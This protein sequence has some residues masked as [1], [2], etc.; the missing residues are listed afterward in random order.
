ML[1]IRSSFAFRYVTTVFE[2]NSFGR[3]IRGDRS[4][5]QGTLRATYMLDHIYPKSYD[6]FTRKASFSSLR[7][8]FRD[9]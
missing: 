9:I 8:N 7:L 3:I 6:E 2:R 1:K 4:F 5:R